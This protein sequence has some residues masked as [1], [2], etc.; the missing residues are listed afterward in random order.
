MIDCNVVGVAKS[1]CSMGVLGEAGM[2]AVGARFG[3]LP[4]AGEEGGTWTW[5]F[6]RAIFV[7]PQRER[8][9][10][11]HKHTE[12]MHTFFLSFFVL[13]FYCTYKILNGNIFFTTRPWHVSN[14]RVAATF[15]V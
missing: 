15:S 9:I 1:W 11:R 2:R 14:V 8:G 6:V 12:G 13:A 4:P 5:R 7:V 10:H 3:L